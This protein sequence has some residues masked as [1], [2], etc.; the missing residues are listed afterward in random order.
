MPVYRAPVSDTLFILNDVLGLERYNNLPGFAD[1]TPEMIEAILGEAAR[2]AE[3]VLFPLNYSGD[4]EGCRRSDDGNVSTPTGFKQAYESY[5]AGGW[6]GLAVPEEFGGQGLP[7]TLH[8]AVGEYTSSANMALMMYPGLTHGAMAAIFVHGTEEQKRTY[9]PKMVEGRWSGTMNL[10]EPHC[11]TDLGL[12]RT[13]AVLQP[14]GSYRISGQKIF[15]SA[16]EHDLTENI[17][18][19]VLARIEG[20]PEGTKGI[21]LFIV[22]KFLVG[23]DG[24]PAGRNGVSCG[25]L[26]H[27]MGIHANATCVMNYDDATGYLIG[28]E[29]RGLPAMFVMMNEAR[30]SVGL[31]GVSISEVA[32]QNAAAYARDRIQGRSLS[33]AKAPD[34]KADP[35]IVHPDIR[36]TLMT[37]RAF[38]EAGRAFLLWT[39]LQSDIAHRATDERERQLADDIL[40]LL[41]PILKGVMTDKGFEHAVMAQQVFGGHGYIEDNGMSQYVRDAR[42]AM[43]YE[44]A[45]GIQALDLVGRKLGLNGGRAVM[46]LFKEIGDFCEENRADEAMA[47]FTKALKKSLGDAQAATMW[48][49]Q[50]A[51]AKPDNAGAGS[52]DYMHLFGLVVLGYMWAKM[53]KAAQTGLASG[54]GARSEFFETKLVTG[55][56][57]MERILPETA[58]RR[59]RVEAG[60]DTMM[61]LPAEAF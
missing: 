56:F 60:A 21:S 7:Y 48:F 1:A 27:K 33:G 8:A 24:A 32:Y 31:Q 6:T 36:R 23:E 42:I 25:A 50:N 49:M 47:P 37:I 17:V 38:N 57:Y 11:G 41:T 30:V 55:R 59:T 14:D 16:G 9:L 29:N 35:I 28:T 52:T 45:N 46:A 12:L 43:I 61:A 10:T 54:D 58:L 13:K 15:I 4:Q 19:L 53:V 5:C 40:G 51:M 22:P 44:G 18:H 26:E 2:M 3:E 20:A 39:A 34:K